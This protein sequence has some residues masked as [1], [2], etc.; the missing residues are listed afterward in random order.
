LIRKVDTVSCHSSKS[1]RA[2]RVFR[3]SSNAFE[4]ISVRFS[5]PIRS[6]RARSLSR[7]SYCNCALLLAMARLFN[8]VGRYIQ[9]CLSSA[10]AHSS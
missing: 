9:P 8:S 1:C 10:L 7:L 5:A 4:T 3:A 6:S 2:P